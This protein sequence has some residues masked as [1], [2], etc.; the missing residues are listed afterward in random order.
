MQPFLTKR[1]TRN[2]I[3]W[4]I[5][6][7]PF[8]IEVYSVSADKEKKAIVVRTTN[9]KYFKE[10]QVHELNRC[11]LLPE[12]QAITITHQHNTLIISVK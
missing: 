4:R 8:P 12:Q 11:G 3:E 2:N 9:K 5:R 1:I 7:L 10:I 6:N